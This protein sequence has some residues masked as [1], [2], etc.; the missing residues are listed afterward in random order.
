MTARMLNNCARTANGNVNGPNRPKNDE[1]R[2]VNAAL[3]ERRGIEVATHS[4]SRTRPAGRAIFL[5]LR[6]C[7]AFI[8]AIAEAERQGEHEWAAALRRAV[9]AFHQRRAGAR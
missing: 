1:R 7:A 8:E 5:N 4:L 6:V 2:G 3:S 9:L